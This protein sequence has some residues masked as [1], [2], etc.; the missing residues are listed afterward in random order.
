MVERI[1]IT[2]ENMKDDDELELLLG[3]IPHATSLS[4]HHNHDHHSHVNDDGYV[5]FVSQTMNGLMMCGMYDDDPSCSYKQNTCIFP[6][7]TTSL[8]SNGS[9]SSFFSSL[10]DKGSPPPPPPPPLDDPTPKPQLLFRSYSSVLPYS[11][12][13][14]K[15][16]E[17]W[18]NELGLAC[19]QGD[20]LVHDHNV[21]TNQI[22]LTRLEASDTYSKPFSDY[23]ARQSHA[24]RSSMF[25]GEMSPAFYGFQQ[26][27]GFPGMQI[28][29]GQAQNLFPESNFH[30][31]VLNF[32]FPVSYQRGIPA[33]DLAVPNG[34]YRSR[35][36]GMLFMEPGGIGLQ[37]NLSN[38]RAVSG[39]NMVEGLEASD[40]SLIIQGESVNQVR[41]KVMGGF[42]GQKKECSLHESGRE[43]G[44]IVGG[45][46]N[47]RIAMTHRSAPSPIRCNT[48]ADAQGYI[49]MFAKDQNGCRYLQSAF[50]EGNPQH[51]Q[52]VFNEII[53]D[54]VELMINPFGNY[55][56]QK[57]LEVCNEE[58]KMHIL[59]EVTRE[60][61][62]LVQI[63]LNT[64][65]T[66]VVQKLIETLKT[67]QQI[68]MVIS[69]LEPGFLA[70]IKDLNGNH[71]IQRCLQCLTNEDNKFCVDI[72]T[73]QHGCCV[74][75]RC[76]NH[77]TGKHQES[78]VLEISSNGL[79]LAQDAFG[80][81]VVQSILELQIPSAVSM[82]ISQ[83]EGNYVHLATQK[84]S[85]HV[86]EKCL[87][88]LDDRA[89]ST[90]IRE[91]LSATHFEQLL[92]DPHANYGALH[93][94]LVK[95]IE[96]HKAISRNSPYSKRI[97][98]H[99]LLKK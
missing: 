21:G 97:F 49:L 87:S 78:L 95:A 30:R 70:L 42:R 76:I 32:R 65:G 17:N 73:H 11:C 84:F 77:S 14:K 6:P 23:D 40:D 44:R 45:C 20:D 47:G 46:E 71:V 41:K 29:P 62:E 52:M 94:S 43:N 3:E 68:M 56:M 99:K 96:S 93:N 22:N 67:R 90:I 80:N 19:N 37:P 98:S 51:V 82:L 75:Q 39:S 24:S 38:G 91:L 86:V 61:R 9:F 55:L 18:F 59:M 26:S 35:Q 72:A 36:N 74:L 10:S 2:N 28:P 66:R 81:Y 83:F 4:H 13:G 58:Q 8:Q 50:D 64:H 16:D 25:N 5:P 69:A 79:L 89:R 33:L 63:S 7:S 85:S 1:E 57:L 12:F 48:L 53:G 88:V 15:I 34:L 54:V 92:Q 60:P 27:H 31:N